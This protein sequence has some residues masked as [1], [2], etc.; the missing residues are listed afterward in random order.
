[1]QVTKK[2]DRFNPGNIPV[3]QKSLKNQLIAYAHDSDEQL[4]NINSD[5]KDKVAESVLQSGVNNH[6]TINNN[7]NEID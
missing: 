6:E 4:F 1:M 2:V 5:H 7:D 3:R